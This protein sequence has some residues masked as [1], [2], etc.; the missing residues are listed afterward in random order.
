MENYK[1][2]HLYSVI[3]LSVTAPAIALHFLQLR[4]IE[5]SLHFPLYF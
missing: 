3:I 2:I 4:E 1:T 5:K